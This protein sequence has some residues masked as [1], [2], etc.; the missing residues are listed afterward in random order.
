MEVTFINRYGAHVEFKQ[1]RLKFSGVEIAAPILVFVIRIIMQ[2]H[3]AFLHVTYV[4][5]YFC[6]ALF[7]FHYTS[8]PIVQLACVVT[9]A[10]RIHWRGHQF[11]GVAVS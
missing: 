9:P 8:I 6:V 4:T 1:P 7:Y 11:Y 5:F 10:V 2:R 3:P